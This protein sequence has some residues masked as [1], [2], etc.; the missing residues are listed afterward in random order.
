MLAIYTAVIGGGDLFGMATDQFGVNWMTGFNEK[1]YIYLERICRYFFATILPV[2]KA[3][4]HQ[5]AFMK[6]RWI[7]SVRLIHLKLLI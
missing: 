2:N 7:N 5:Y 6:K 3:K 1:A 4:P